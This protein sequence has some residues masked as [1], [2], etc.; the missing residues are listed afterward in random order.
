MSKLKET[1]LST[2]QIYKGTLLDVRRDE[3]TLPNGKTSAREY[4]K[5]PGAACMIPVLPDGNIALIKQYRYPV[6]SEMIELPAGKLDPGEKPEACAKRELE[7]EI[8]YSAG[9]LTFVCNIHPAIG[10]ASE[11]MW[12]YLAE[13]LVKTVENTDHDEFLVLMPTHLDDAIK[14][15]WDGKITDVKTIIGLLWAER[16]LK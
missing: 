2:E 7:E 6:Q 12:I 4:I 5:H 15:V 8:G 16:L 14:M 3:I 10:F 11:K 9:K 1:Q 13:D